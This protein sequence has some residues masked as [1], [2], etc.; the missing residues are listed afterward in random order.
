MAVYGVHAQ[1]RQAPDPSWYPVDLIYLLWITASWHYHQSTHQAW[2]IYSN[3]YAIKT[4]CMATTNHTCPILGAFQVPCFS[5]LRPYHD[6]RPP[7]LSSGDLWSFYLWFPSMCG[8]ESV[9]ISQWFIVDVTQRVVVW[10][11]V[12]W[13]GVVIK[14]VWCEMGGDIAIFAVLH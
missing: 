9:L 4:F 10:I 12:Q 2:H 11:V 5:I 8:N 3:I 14:L 7:T 1:N 6:T 13:C